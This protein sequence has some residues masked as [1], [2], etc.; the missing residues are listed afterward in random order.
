MGYVDV[1]KS[2]CQ[3]FAIFPKQS[4]ERFLE[5]FFKLKFSLED[6]WK[7]I[8]L[9]LFKSLKLRLPHGLWLSFSI[10]FHF[11]S[12]ENSR[13]W[14]FQVQWNVFNA[15]FAHLHFRSISFT[16]PRHDWSDFDFGY[17][18][19]SLM[20]KTRPPTHHT[21]Y[22]SKSHS[23]HVWETCVF[24]VNQYMVRLTQTRH[25]T[26]ALEDYTRWC[27]PNATL[28]NTPFP[29]HWPLRDT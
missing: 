29:A 19:F 10:T 26:T 17:F 15:K 20:Y 3:G 9:K 5:C 4:E 27:T 23:D 16:W 11:K 28:P 1:W 12:S 14:Y 24:P 13:T 18:H 2:T 21:C 6:S 8:S 7:R 22:I 25:F